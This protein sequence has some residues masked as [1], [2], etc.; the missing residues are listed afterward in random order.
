MFYI[1]QDIAL[2]SASGVSLIL[3]VYVAYLHIKLTRILAGKDARSLEDSIFHIKSGLEEHNKFR[4][5]LEK[6][7]AHVEK[8]LKTSVRGMET[9][10]FNALGSG[11]HQSFA[12]AHLNEH[13]DGV[14]ISS[15]YARDR[16]SFFA[17]PVKNFQSEFELSPEETEALQKAQAKL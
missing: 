2:Y 16:M 4:E 17:K 6:Y 9:I 15:L 7:L 12:S 3:L 1:P 11:G 14:I 10:R 13:G 8:R 5:D